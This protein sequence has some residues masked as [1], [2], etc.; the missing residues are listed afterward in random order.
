[1]AVTIKD[2]TLISVSSV[3]TEFVTSAFPRETRNTFRIVEIVGGL[4][5]VQLARPS[6]TKAVGAGVMTGALIGFIND[7]LRLQ[8]GKKAA[9]TTESPPGNRLPDGYYMDKMGHRVP[10]Y[11]QKAGELIWQY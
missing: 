6:N 11:F 9:Y 4:L 1:M 5:T 2:V 7:T 8:A 3:A 10:V